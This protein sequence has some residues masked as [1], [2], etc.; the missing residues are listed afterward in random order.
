VCLASSPGHD[1]E[2]ES[3][4]IVRDDGSLRIQGRNLRLFG[5]FIPDTGRVCGKTLLSCGSRAAVALDACLRG[6]GW[7]A[8]GSW[9]LEPR[10]AM[11]PL[12]DTSEAET[13][14]GIFS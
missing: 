14:P 9:V 4:A 12:L 1:R 3:D 10:S 5:I 13:S 2:I 11:S 6:A 7:S 8:A